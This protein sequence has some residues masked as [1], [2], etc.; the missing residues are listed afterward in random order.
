MVLVKD[1]FGVFHIVMIIKRSRSLISLCLVATLSLPSLSYAN[2]SRVDS[3]ELPDIGTVAGST[4]TIDQ[5][6]IY[7]DAYM[8]M[9]RSSKPIIN[10]PVIN[11]YIDI[12]G[13]RLVAHA[14]DV[15]TPFTFFMIR[16]RNINAFA[17][18][19][20]YIA[21]HSGLLLHAQ[22]ES[23]LASVMAHEIAHVTQ[24]HL[25]RSMEEQARRSPATIAA[26][27]GSLLLAIAAPQA[28]IAAITATT[29]GSMQSQINY[30]RSNEK[31]ADRF[32]I[33]TLAKAGFDVQAMPRFFGRLADEYRYAS[34]PPPMLLTHPLPED[35]ITDSRARA[36]QYPEVRVPPSLNY[37][38]ARS[39]VVA[40]Y[41][42]ISSD[43]AL[44]WF[45][46]TQKKSQEN[47]TDAFDYGKALVYLD[48]KQY[49]QAEPL[50]QALLK[51][52][53]DN[54]FYL[55]AMTDLLIETK[56]THDAEQLLAQALQQKPNNAVLLINY[57]NAL[58][59]GEK[60]AE[61]IRLLQRYTHDNPNDSNGW[62]LLA[63]ANHHQGNEPEELA[64]RAELLALGA[65]WNKAI[66][67]YTQA[68]QRA[69]LGSLEQARYDARI[70]QLMV[71]RERFLSLK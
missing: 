65:N 71:Q 3:I 33:A 41:A 12:I 49:Q 59:K 51:S 10:D 34:T 63:E 54:N 17:F 39:R 20:G 58:F 9:L 29:A 5:E 19:G 21:L 53:P 60:Y 31:E 26:L 37:H 57:A 36:Q 4:L 40:R 55:D 48:T 13:H 52:N 30:T 6:R 67:F 43:A 23:E 28:G 24:R 22:S 62:S 8:R 15:K 11:E 44:D 45:N 2:V 66:Q 25:A 69:T 64:A 38:L 70:D 16:D 7:G 1:E 61:A 50:L 46:R 32:G 27:A 56:R 68:S 35:R 47:L 18:F 42:G 14:D